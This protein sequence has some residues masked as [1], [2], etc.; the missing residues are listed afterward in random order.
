MFRYGSQRIV[1]MLLL[2]LCVGCSS[3]PEPQ[4]EVS[5]AGAPAPAPTAIDDPSL[6]RF[7][8]PPTVRHKTAVAM[9]DDSIMGGMVVIEVDLDET[10]KVTDL[11]LVE[12]ETTASATM[13]EAAMKAVREWTFNPAIHGGEPVP[14]RFMLPFD[15]SDR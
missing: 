7:D 15:F 11:K 1:P 2:G 3:T 9:P 14:S 12:S 4:A 13:Q 6:A 5:P 8:S 10:G